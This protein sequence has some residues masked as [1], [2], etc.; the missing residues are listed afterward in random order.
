MLS[1]CTKL[2]NYFKTVAVAGPNGTMSSIGPIAGG[3]A[4]AVVV[5]IIVVLVAFSLLR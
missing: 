1:M 2:Q 3:L 5:I 4:G